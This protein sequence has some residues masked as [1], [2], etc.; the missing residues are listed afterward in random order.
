MPSNRKKAGRDS[1]PH[2][3]QE[4]DRAPE[5]LSIPL[6][7]GDTLA[8]P[9][10]NHGGGQASPQILRGEAE[11]LR[12]PVGDEG[13][14]D[15][16]E[17]GR[18]DVLERKEAPDIGQRAIDALSGTLGRLQSPVRPAEPAD[19]L[20]VL[21]NDHRAVCEPFRQRFQAVLDTVAGQSLGTFEA[22]SGVATKINAVRKALG[23]AFR[24]RQN[25]AHPRVNLRCLK[26]ARS[27]Q[28]AFQAV[29]TQKD[30]KVFYSG[31][32]FPPLEAFFP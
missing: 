6:E 7:S 22:N 17:T 3:S 21:L 15:T 26:P 29:G 13:L 32:T 2:R 31:T 1:A 23:L 20:G 14:T 11:T 18:I 10:Q 4:S 8:I 25:P 19:E 9:L 30:Q 16:P 24:L 27:V 28:G 12:I 5:T